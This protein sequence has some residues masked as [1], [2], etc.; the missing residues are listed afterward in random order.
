MLSRRSGPISAA[1]ERGAAEVPLEVAAHLHLEVGEALRHR[2][3]AQAAHLLVGIA[4]PAGRGRVGGEA[5]PPHLRL[6]RGARR[7]VPLEDRE[8]LVGRERVRD[9]HEG[10]AVDR[11]LR[12][13]V[14]EELP[15][16]LALAPRPQVPDRVHHRA[17]RHVDDAL[18]RADPAQLRVLGEAV[19][20]AAEVGGD[21]LELAADHEPL[22]GAGGGDADLGAV[23]VREGEAVA[24]VRAVRLEGHVDGGVVADVQGVG[25]VHLPG[26]GEAHV[27]G[28]QGGDLHGGSRLYTALSASARPALAPLRALHSPLQ[29]VE[30]RLR[31]AALPDAHLRRVDVADGDVDGDLEAPGLREAELLARVDAPVAHEEEGRAGAQG[32]VDTQVVGEQLHA[33]DRRRDRRVGGGGEDGDEAERGDDPGGEAGQRARGPSR[34]WPR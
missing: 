30:H 7:R 2:L 19:V 23:A 4:E 8:R 10:H 12:G 26:G 14:G 9:P 18:L 33:H 17:E 11:L 21:L 22:E 27:A 29:P 28:A 6:A 32:G 34:S 3:A 31:H 16:R 15:D 20:E 24:R 5:V 25:A 13:E 1:H